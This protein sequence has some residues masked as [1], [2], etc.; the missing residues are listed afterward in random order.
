ML[1]VNATQLR[2]RFA[3]RLLRR[4]RAF[5][6]TSPKALLLF[7][8]E[9]AAGIAG[10]RIFGYGGDL[11]VSGRITK[12]YAS[13]WLRLGSEDVWQPFVEPTAPLP[14]TGGVQRLLANFVIHDASHELLKAGK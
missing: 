5:F 6:L 4:L 11:C 8:L 14:F 2:G 3:R 9:A 1:G 12:W 7:G 13:A 10:V